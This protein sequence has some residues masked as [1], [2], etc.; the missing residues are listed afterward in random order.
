M[1]V[2]SGSHDH[3]RVSSCGCKVPWV[4][5]VISEFCRGCG[6]HGSV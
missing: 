1:A 4:L 5:Q 3:N 2:L 6:F